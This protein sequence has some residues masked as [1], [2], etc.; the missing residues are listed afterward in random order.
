MMTCYRGRRDGK[1]QKPRQLLRKLRRKVANLSRWRDRLERKCLLEQIRA[2]EFKVNGK[3][4]L[5]RQIVRRRKA[6]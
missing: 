5:R 1:R 4:V 3:Q 2:L 6:A